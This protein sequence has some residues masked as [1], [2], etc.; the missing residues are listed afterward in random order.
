MKRPLYWSSLIICTAGLLMCGGMF[1]RQWEEYRT[2]ETAYAS[3]VESATSEL[4]LTDSTGQAE[5]N[6]PEDPPL[7][8]DFE[9]LRQVNPEV[10]GWIYIPDTVIS[11]PVV[12]GTDNTYYLDHLFDGTKNSAGCLFL[13]SR[14]QGLTGQNSVIYGHH[15]K[16]GTLFASLTEYQDQAY[17]EAHPSV[18]LLTPEGTQEIRL[19]SAYVAG[20]DEDAWQLT[21]SSQ[22]EYVQWLEGLRERSCFTSDVVPFIS[23]RVVTLSTCDYSF[24]NARFVCHGVLWEQ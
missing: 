6:S 1:L 20:M 8:V 10:I 5:G 11:Y 18:F 12:Q 4:H 22:K 16:N 13:D 19:F 14:C 21:F 24:P 7:Q 9:A 3:L 17:Y 2:G 23:D 15:M